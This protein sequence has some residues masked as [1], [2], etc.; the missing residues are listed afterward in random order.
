MGEEEILR[1]NKVVDYVCTKAKKS[2]RGKVTN[3]R[4]AIK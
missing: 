4:K 2:L 1:G 3:I